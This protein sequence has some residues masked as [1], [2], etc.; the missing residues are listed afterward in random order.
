VRESPSPNLYTNGTFKV[1]RKAK[2]RTL[3]WDLE[4]GNLVSPAPQ[5]EDIRAKKKPRLE[6]R[7]SAST[8]ENATKLPSLDTTV[9]LPPP[10]V[11]DDAPP[12]AADAAATANHADSDPVMDMYLNARAT[13]ARRRWTADE[14]TRLKKA[15][16]VQTHDGERKNWDAIA[17]L[18]PGRTRTQCKSR[19]YNAFDHRNVR[20]THMGRWTPDEDDKLK[21][22][23]QIHGIYKNWFTITALVPSR[24]KKQCRARWRDV[25][26]PRID[27]TTAREGKWTRDEDEKLKYA[28][29]M[30]NGKNWFAITALVP[31]RTRQQC[32][33]RW[34]GALNP[35]IDWTPGR[36]DKWTPDEDAKLK[37]VVQMQGVRK[38][39]VLI[40]TQVP[41][42][43]KKQCWDRWKKCMGP[44]RSAVGKEEHGTLNK[45]PDLRQDRP[46]S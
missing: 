35:S 10:H 36:K 8:G 13:G 46:F 17:A 12:E 24:T 43:T 42:R 1:P 22:A 45:L 40:A 20:T 5:D 34:H 23:V 31:G 30:H 32:R 15:V 28:V 38:D 26:G 33:S 21:D 6:E 19:W 3:P 27:R 16:L 25:L 37:N 44:I 29:Q 9:A 11:A 41:G 14:D 2:K 4:A 18:T 39:W 7:F